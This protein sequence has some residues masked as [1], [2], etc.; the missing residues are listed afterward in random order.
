[1]S[2]I[3]YYRDLLKQRPRIE[4]FQRAIAAVVTPGDRVLEIGAGLGTFAFFAADAGAARVWAIDGDPIVHVAKAVA[5]W[6]G[7]ADRAE[8]IRGWIPSVE[9]PERADVVIFED[10]P[11]RLLDARTFRLLRWVH[12]RYVS[13]EVRAV[14]AAARF[15]AAPVSSRRMW[16]DVG[17]FDADDTAYGIDWSPSRDYQ[18]NLPINTRLGHED[19][20]ADPMC[21]GT[22]RFDSPPS[23]EDLVGHAEWTLRTGCTVH[24]IAYW[25]DLELGG[26]EQLS[27]RPGV[28]P[29]S[30]GHL[31]PG[32]WGHLFLPLEE[33][34][35]MPSEEI[36]TLALRPHPL[37]DGCPG[38]LSWDV[39]AGGITRR[40]YEL[41][42]VPA[43]VAD[44][45]AASPDFVPELDLAGHLEAQVLQLT[46][47]TRSVRDIAEAI[48]RVRPDLAQAEAERLVVAV[49]RNRIR[50][51]R[52][53]V[54]AGKEVR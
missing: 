52:A 17:P 25:F 47:G 54:A 27:N 33:P 40:G 51:G 30:W 26:G 45:E 19:L 31:T 11:P 46:D 3:K 28:T 20:A 13:A 2:D 43:S 50:L 18:S 37:P 35:D 16:E 39:T 15:Y 53:T 21:L 23:I 41:A 24:G 4:A 6:N 8:F 49:L 42:S 48:V 29:G 7:Y 9:L 10:F 14:P 5:A 36:L 34:V 22:V 12:Q 44:F 38:W 1:M 32:S